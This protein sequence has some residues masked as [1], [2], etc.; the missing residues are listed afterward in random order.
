MAERE[1]L[2]LHISGTTAMLGLIGPPVAHPPAPAI[3]K[4]F[5]QDFGLIWAYLAVATPAARAAGCKTC[6]GLGMLLCQE[7]AFRLYSGLEMAVEEM[8]ALLYT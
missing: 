3:N 5:F 6:D 4:H 7:A 2:A 1:E 8:R